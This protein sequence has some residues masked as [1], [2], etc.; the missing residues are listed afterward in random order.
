MGAGNGY[1]IVL[2]Q[3]N[4]VWGVGR[5]FRG[6]LGDVNKDRRYTFGLT[7]FVLGAGSVAAGGRIFWDGVHGLSSFLRKLPLRQR[8]VAT[9]FVDASAVERK[10]LET[11]SSAHLDWR[12]ESLGDLLNDLVPLLPV[13]RKYL[14][15]QKV[16]TGSGSMS[17]IDT[18]VVQ[19][20]GQFVATPLTH[21]AC[22]LLRVACGIVNEWGSWMEGCPCHEHIWKMSCTWT[23]KLDFSNKSSVAANVVGKAHAALKWRREDWGGGFRRSATRGVQYSF[24]WSPRCQRRIA[25][26]SRPSY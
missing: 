22:E 13:L 12:W 10:T 5:N 17:T 8:L 26:P 24:A 4:S 1:S 19:T 7:Q 16:L 3:D 18:A 20:A 25:G 9:C 21:S 11:F 14:D 6:Q 15:T 23:R 2:K